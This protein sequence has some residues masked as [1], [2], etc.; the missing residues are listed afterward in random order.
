MVYLMIEK[1]AICELERNYFIFNKLYSWKALD[2]YL[3]RNV[4]PFQQKINCIES[5]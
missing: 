3:D 2:K 1:L 4:I 5:K